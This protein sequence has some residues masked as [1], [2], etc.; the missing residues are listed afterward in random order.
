MD[1]IILFL[2]EISIPFAIVG[3]VMLLQAFTEA[4]KDIT[5]EEI[6]NNIKNKNNTK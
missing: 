2:Q 1:T 5:F 3:F 6:D 4:P